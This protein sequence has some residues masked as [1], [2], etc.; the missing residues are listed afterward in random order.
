MVRIFFFII[1]FILGVVGPFEAFLLAAVVY[2]LR[3]TAYEL[4]V[5]AAMIDAYY[6][7]SYETFPKYTLVTVGGLFILEWIKQQLSLYNH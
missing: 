5:F 3:F 4:I 2:A 7:I 1:I 6:S